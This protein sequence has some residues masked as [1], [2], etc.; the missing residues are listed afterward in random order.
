MFGPG[1][2]STENL[3]MP[4]LIDVKGD[5]LY[6]VRKLEGESPKTHVY[7][8]INRVWQDSIISDDFGGFISPDGETLYQGQEY[9]ERTATGWSETKIL[10]SLQV[11]FP[12]MGLAVSSEGTYVFDD[13]D[14]IGTIYYSRLMD[15]VREAPKAFG[16]EINTGKWTA[17]PFIAPDESYI[18]W[19]SEREG[20]YGETDLYISF[21]R[22][23]GSWGEA[24]NMGDEINSEHEDGGGYVTRD[25]K[26]FFFNRINLTGSFQTSEENIYWVDGQIIEDLKKQHW[27]Q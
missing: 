22:E 19:D 17:H 11:D 13:H 21:R 10:E 26:Y 7:H 2:V 12:I 1:I 5:K 23:D 3:E 25:G 4:T 6:F 18:I 14:S 24:I 20:G 15:G 27:A 8:E 16:R 9:K